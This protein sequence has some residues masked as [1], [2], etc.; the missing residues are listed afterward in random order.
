[1]SAGDIDG[2]GQLDLV[3]GNW[4]LNSHWRATPAHP[5]TLYFG[6]LA[7]RNG[8]D[9]LETEFDPQRGQ[10]VPR[11]LRDTVA[12]GIPWIA[13][14][15]PTHTAWSRALVSDVLK[16]HRSQMREVTAAT[17]ATTVF[18]NRKGRFEAR[19]LPAEAQFAPT[20]GVC[21]ADFDG[22]GLE[23]L[24][25]AQNFFAFRLEDSRLDASRSLLLRGD[26]MG[27]F[28]SVPGQA[29]G[30][31]VH[32]EQR[33]AAAADF[34]QD[35]RTDLVVTQ[36]GAATRLFRNTAARPGLRVRLAGPAGNPDG[37]GAALR[38]KSAAGLG[39]AR[40]VHAG[41]G[42]WSQDSSRPVMTLPDSPAEIHVSWP[43]GRRTTQIIHQQVG[44]V[45][46]KW[47]E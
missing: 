30:L 47:R 1:V 44:E 35:G 40:E 10:L 14:R 17:L 3:A 19:P 39:P 13:E 15:F 6:D 2:D 28:A 38:L 22:D 33:G 24:F 36:N 4:G 8:V 46:V 27:G 43:G 45:V 5:L 29:S 32:G 26:G 34:D 21:V 25:L 41:S 12:N 23:D 7:G 31:I 18:L 9:I 11:H 16:D 37:I 42:Y 20:F